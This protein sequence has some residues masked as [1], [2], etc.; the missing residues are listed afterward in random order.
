MTEIAAVRRFNR[1]Y[2]ATLG[3]LE[4]HLPDSDL[5]LPEARL[6]YELAA[7]GEA[8]A[9]ALGR[10]TAMDKAQVSRVMARLARRGLVAARADP[11]HGRRQLLALTSAGAAAFARLNAG[12]EAQVDTLLAPLPS[13]ERAELV[14]A[15]AAVERLLR[16]PVAPAPLELRSPAVGDLAWITHRQALLYA[17]EYGWNTD[18]EALVLRILA[19][20]AAGFDAA[21]EDG[22]VVT[23]GGRIGGSIFL[24][25]GEAAGEAKL[26]LLYVE[27][28]LRG[29]SAGRLLVDTCVVRARALGYCRLVLWTNSVLAAARRVYEAAGFALVVEE[30]HHSFGQDLIGQ[31]W[32]LDL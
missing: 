3:L 18:Y 15:M 24:M 22:W 25:R 8:T 27:P 5:A 2:T 16:P 4:P 31:T 20:Y 11:G 7:A 6:V 21:R 28:W 23:R 13:P 19:D 12:T 14:T 9:A 10:R 26:R 17:R 30:P 1:F 29:S 32:A